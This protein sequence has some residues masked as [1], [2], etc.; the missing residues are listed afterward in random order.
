M[1]I[2]SIYIRSMIYQPFDRRLFFSMKN[3]IAN[4]QME[5]SFSF[6]VG[7]IQIGVVGK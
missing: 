4:Q 6:L 2:P 3:S 1:D 5:W 7:G